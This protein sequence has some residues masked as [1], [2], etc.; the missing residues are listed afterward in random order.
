MLNAL[1]RRKNDII[2]GITTFL[3]MSYIIVVNPSI[4]S[5]PGTGMSFNGV[6]AATVILSFSMTLM[7]GLYAKLPFGVAPAMGIN[8]FVTFGLIL[9]QKIPWPIAMGMVFWAGVFFLLISVTPLRTMIVKALPQ[10]IKLGA[11]IGIGLFLSFIGLKNSGIIVSDPVTFV[12]MGEWEISSVL[13]VIGL[14]VIFPLIARKNPFSFLI[15]IA[16][17]TILARIFGLI[18]FPVSIVA[19]PDFESVFLKLD[20]MGALHWVLLPS[21]LVLVFTDLFDSL[22]TFV[23]V[24]K[25]GNLLDEKGNPIRL[26]EGLIVDSFATF[27]AGLLGTSSGT[28]FIES[29]AGIEAGARSGFAS[30]VTAFCFLPFLFFSPLLGMVPAYATAPVLICVGL[31]MFRNIV[32]LDTKKIEDWVPAVVTILLIPLTFSI[33]KGFLCGLFLHT[34][35]Y[36]LTGRLKEISSA[37]WVLG[38]LSGTLLWVGI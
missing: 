20:V 17:V 12:R 16:T 13:A 29:A 7:M 30:V 38:V 15:S 25:A 19:K 37:M 6:M 5:T 23:G 2:G 10:N 4:M 18:S 31:M 22:S 24:A 8:A 28:T 3:T 33:T 32:E 14:L 21:I 27:F 35:L 11:T 34:I 36:A 9:G 1:E 26:K